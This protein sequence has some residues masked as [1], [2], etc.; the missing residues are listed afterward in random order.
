MKPGIEPGVFIVR[1]KGRFNSVPGMSLVARKVTPTVC[2]PALIGIFGVQRPRPVV[3]A[4][5]LSQSKRCT[6]SPSTVISSRSPVIPPS[7]AWK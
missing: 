4:I 7:T 1:W 5:S 3:L 6:R 2:R